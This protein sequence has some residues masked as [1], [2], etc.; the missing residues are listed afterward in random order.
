MDAVWHAWA[1]AEDADTLQAVELKAAVI[2]DAASVRE[3]LLHLLGGGITRVWREDIPAALG[4][5]LA[6][7]VDLPPEVMFDPHEVTV[8]FVRDDDDEQ[9][10]E[11]KGAFQVGQELRLEPGEHQLVPMVFDL[12]G[13]VIERY[14]AYTFHIAIDLLPATALRFWVLHPEEQLL[15]PLS[16]PALDA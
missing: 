4:V 9:L 5:A 1:H 16:P 12:H 6:L 14:G 15:P 3:G 13:A 11:I 2:C 7:I 8:A 10:S